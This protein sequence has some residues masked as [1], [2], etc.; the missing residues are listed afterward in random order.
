MQRFHLCLA[1]IILTQLQEIV[2]V[3]GIGI[4]GGDA[5]IAVEDDNTLECLTHRNH[6]PSLIVL[7]LFAH[8][9]EPYLGI[10]HHELYLLLTAGGIEG[11]GDG[12]DAPGA[13]ITKQ[14]LYGVL[15]EDTHVFLQLHTKVQHGV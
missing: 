15:R 2:E 5:Y 10:A 3:H 7:L 8:E 13:E 12:T 14:V 6:T 1:R 9:E 4:V 11:D